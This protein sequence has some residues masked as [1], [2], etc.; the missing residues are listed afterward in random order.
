MNLN[1]ESHE[2]NIYLASI[3]EGSDLNY[4]KDG[5]DRPMKF[6]S[7]SAVKKHLEH[8]QFDNVWLV[9]NT[10]YDEMVGLVSSPETIRMPLHW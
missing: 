1:I 10:P 4:I 3:E 7:I 6:A 5:K 2:G 9:H 8:R